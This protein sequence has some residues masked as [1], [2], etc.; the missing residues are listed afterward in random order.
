MSETLGVLLDGSFPDDNPILFNDNLNSWDPSALMIVDALDDYSWAGGPAV[1]GSALNNLVD[2]RAGAAASGAISVDANGWFNGGAVEGYFNTNAAGMSLATTTPSF[3]FLM[4]VK[5][6]SGNAFPGTGSTFYGLGGYAANTSSLSAF[7][8][9]LQLQGAASSAFAINISGTTLNI[10]PAVIGEATQIAGSAVYNGTNYTIKAFRNGVQTNAAT[11]AY[12]LKDPGN[13]NYARLG[14]VVGLSVGEF[15]YA[16][17][18]L[19]QLSDDVDPAA[20]IARD[21]AENAARFA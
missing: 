10:G 7:A 18:A 14:R 20:V 5:V 21:W 16:R 9:T 4:W 19:S 1:N 3:L 6:K 15:S 17:A 12:P 2:G 8:L 13:A 11:A